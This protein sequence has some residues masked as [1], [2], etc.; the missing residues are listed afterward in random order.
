MI[1]RDKLKI[2]KELLMIN[3]QFVA[4]LDLCSGCQLVPPKDV[5]GGDIE[6]F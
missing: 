1:F 3:G 2:G 6:L 5:H 4:R